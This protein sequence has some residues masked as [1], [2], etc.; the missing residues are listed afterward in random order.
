[1]CAACNAFSRGAGLSACDVSPVVY[2][3]GEIHRTQR[4]RLAMAG[5]QRLRRQELT[6][7]RTA[8]ALQQLACEG[9]NLSALPHDCQRY[10]SIE[11]LVRQIV[12][13]SCSAGILALS[14][15]VYTTDWD[16][17]PGVVMKLYASGLMDRSGGNARRSYKLVRIPVLFER[18]S[19]IRAEYP[20][21]LLPASVCY[22]AKLCFAH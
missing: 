13:I 15:R 1:M 12:S 4:D 22:C 5:K 17:F 11:H 14:H 10:R 7:S 9:T 18:F 16:T 2:A 20:P 19:R 8:H 6:V 21:I 3:V